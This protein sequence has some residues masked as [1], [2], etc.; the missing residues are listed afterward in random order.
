M[1]QHEPHLLLQQGF[2]VER[3]EG[4]QLMKRH[5]PS[6]EISTDKNLVDLDWFRTTAALSLDVDEKGMYGRGWRGTVT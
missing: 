1:K 4:E 2:L 6:L 5:V 3:G